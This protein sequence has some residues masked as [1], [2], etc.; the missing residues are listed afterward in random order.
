MTAPVR[1][2]FWNLLQMLSQIVRKSGGHFLA[3]QKHDVAAALL[4][5]ED[6]GLGKR[7][8]HIRRNGQPAPLLRQRLGMLHTGI[9]I[10]IVNILP[11]LVLLDQLK[12]D[13]AL[14]INVRLPVRLPLQCLQN[15]QRLYMAAEFLHPLREHLLLT[16]QLR[17]LFRKQ[18]AVLLRRQAP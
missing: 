7:C 3:H 13:D 10:R 15:P 12:G 9:Q 5:P 16:F 8:G 6:H 14:G 18:R 2:V 4:S 11:Q 1:W 17:K